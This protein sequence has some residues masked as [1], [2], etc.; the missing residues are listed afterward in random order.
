MYPKNG[1][2][3]FNIALQESLQR[4]R[5]SEENV[6]VLELIEIAPGEILRLVDR[7]PYA[8]TFG[9]LA[10]YKITDTVMYA[11]KI[12]FHTI[13]N[14][15]RDGFRVSWDART[16]I[17][18]PMHEA[19]VLFRAHDVGVPSPTLFATL[20]D[21]VAHFTVMQ[22]IEGST[23]QSWMANNPG[24]LHETNPMV[25]DIVY[26]LLSGL[27]AAHRDG[28]THNDVKP[29]NAMVDDAGRLTF[30]D[31]GSSV[32]FPQEGYAPRVVGTPGCTLAKGARTLC[33]RQEL[34]SNR[35]R[36]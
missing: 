33:I 23:L 11:V 4:V 6:N 22:A 12:A 34:T 31:F 8:T 18:D 27:E 24:E 15:Q 20:Q 28:I 19:A 30:L 7:V 26:S 5:E 25:R 36:A 13:F 21:D 17:D 1:S 10:F 14:R 9:W 2:E 32:Q 35:H 3:L 29:A 16:V